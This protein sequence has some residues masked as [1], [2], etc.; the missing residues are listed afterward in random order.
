MEHAVTGMI[1]IARSFDSSGE[2]DSFR[3]CLR[4]VARPKIRFRIGPPPRSAELYRQVAVRCFLPHDGNS[5]RRRVA[6]DMLP[7]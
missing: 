4:D 7:N 5:V 2:W 6:L 3:Q 1:H